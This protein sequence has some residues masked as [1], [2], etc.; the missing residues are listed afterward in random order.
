MHTALLLTPYKTMI[1]L[2]YNE[3]NLALFFLHLGEGIVFHPS[4]FVNFLPHLLIRGTPV[5]LFISSTLFDYSYLSHS[6]PFL[7][8]FSGQQFYSFSSYHAIM[9]YD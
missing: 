1:L 9:L 6:R 8:T 4:P 2:H 3:L 7:S 5:F